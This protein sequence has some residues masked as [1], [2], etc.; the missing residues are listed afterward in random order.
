[1]SIHVVKPE[2]FFL[3]KSGKARHPDFKKLS[4]E[5]IDKHIVEQDSIAPKRWQ[6][7]RI[8]AHKDRL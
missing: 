1:M 3:E 8:P 5:Y 7:Q 4:E 6:G 2:R